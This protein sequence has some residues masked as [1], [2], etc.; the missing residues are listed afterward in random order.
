VQDDDQIPANAARQSFP[1]R[2][3]QQTFDIEKGIG[4][5]LP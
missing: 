3:R 5:Q 2:A 1:E 4:Q